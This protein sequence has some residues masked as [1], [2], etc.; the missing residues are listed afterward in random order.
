MQKALASSFKLSRRDRH[1][2]QIEF[3]RKMIPLGKIKTK[4]PKRSYSIRKKT[5][6]DITKKAQEKKLG[7]DSSFFL[8]W[9]SNNIQL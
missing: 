5:L 2:K 8:N 4:F 3:H 1:L 9:H 7:T 6:L